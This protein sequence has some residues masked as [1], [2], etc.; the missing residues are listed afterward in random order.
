MVN[1]SPIL[2]K[3]EE[4][5]SVIPTIATLVQENV[6]PVTLLVNEYVKVVPEHIEAGVS[7]LVSIGKGLTLTVTFCVFTQPSGVVRV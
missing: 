7:V 6:V 4:E 2:P 5:P 1:I 3:P